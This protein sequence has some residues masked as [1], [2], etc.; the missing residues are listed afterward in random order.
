MWTCSPGN[1]ASGLV[2][3]LISWEN[4]SDLYSGNNFFGHIP[5]H[6]KFFG[7]KFLT[8]FVD[9]VLEV[10]AYVCFVLHRKDPTCII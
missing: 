7:H 9:I 5:G 4:N 8:Q 2:S 1:L 6:N 10:F 3:G